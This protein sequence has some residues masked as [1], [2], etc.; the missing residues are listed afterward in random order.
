MKH[1][2]LNLFN[3][4]GLLKTIVIT[5]FLLTNCNILFGQSK[6]IEK[7]IKNKRNTEEDKNKNNLS[8][9]NNKNEYDNITNE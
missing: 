9:N 7:E 5:I 2:N 4:H 8:L 3:K 1:L 6:Q